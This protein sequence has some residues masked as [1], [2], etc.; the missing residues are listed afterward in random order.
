[1]WRGMT[2]MFSRA[3]TALTRIEEWF[4]AASL[5]L[6]IG[7]SLTQIVA[8][9]A[10]DAGFPGMDNFSRQLVLYVAFLGA[11][12]AV[13]WDRHIRV[14]IVGHWLSLRWRARLYRPFCLLSA[15]VCA[16]FLEAAVRFWQ[17]SWQFSADSERW[18]VLLGTIIPAGYLLLLV[19]FLLE[20]I[21]GHGTAATETP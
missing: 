6:L 2:G 14:D 20:L 16:L 15:L 10:F 3:R 1:M 12:L 21:I 5:L 13:T 8:R 9:N 7:L 11:A 4:A 17:Q 19:H 18:L